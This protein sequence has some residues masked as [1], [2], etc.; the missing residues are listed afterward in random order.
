[1]TLSEAYQLLSLGV[2]SRDAQTV[3]RS[4]LVDSKDG[5]TFKLVAVKKSN[6]SQNVRVT[7]LPMDYRRWP[8]IIGFA[9]DLPSLCGLIL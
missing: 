1:M 2:I 6:F 3:L 5:H 8:R 7:S 9:T 4:L